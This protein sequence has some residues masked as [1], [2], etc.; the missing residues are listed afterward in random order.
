TPAEMKSLGGATLTK[1]P[2]NSILLTGPNNTPESYTI[3]AHT[4]LT[5]ITG[6]RLEVLADKAL[7]ANGPG[8]A[9]N[10]NFVLNEFKISY[11]KQD[12]KDKATAVQ[13]TRPQATISQDGFNISQAIDN[14]P[15]TGWA[16]GN[17]LGRSHTAVFEVANKFG[18]KEGTTLTFS[19]DQQFTG[20]QHNIG[21]FRLAVTTSRPPVLLQG[22]TPENIAKLLDTPAE[23]RN[24]DQ[25]SALA[26]YY[27]SIDPA[28]AQLQRAVNEFVVPANARSLG[29]Q[30]LA[31]ALINSPAFLFNH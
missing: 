14:N 23:Q 13:L 15:S 30:D 7:P 27:R 12:S 18:F 25:K 9:P 16:V 20:K 2:D 17:G 8:R 26:N 19:L 22:Q 11:V 6:I 4:T 10:G 31:W 5:G 24:A 3:T 29:A 28:L 1:Q 21:K